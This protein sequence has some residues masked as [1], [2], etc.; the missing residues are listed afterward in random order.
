MQ[1]AQLLA[2]VGS[3][4]R[5]IRHQGHPVFGLGGHLQ[6]AAGHL[7]CRHIRPHPQ[8]GHRIRHQAHAP[9]LQ[10]APD[11]ADDGRVC[12]DA[13]RDKADRHARVGQERARQPRLAMHERRHR[14]EQ[15][16]AVAN[17]RVEALDGL[18]VGCHGVARAHHDPAPDQAADHVE[19]ARQLRR[20]GDD[21][22]AG[23]RRPVAHRLEA[24]RPQIVRVVGA[25]LLDVEEG[26]F[27]VQAQRQRAAEV[28]GRVHDDLARGRD[29]LQRRG[30]DGRQERGHPVARILCRDRPNRGWVRGEIV[31]EPAVELQVDEPRREDQAVRVEPRRARGTGHIG[32]GADRDDP[33][34]VDEHRAVGD[35]DGGRVGGGM[36]DVEHGHWISGRLAAAMDCPTRR[37][38]SSGSCRLMRPASSGNSAARTARAPS[39]MICPPE[40]DVTRPRIRTWL[41]S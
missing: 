33:P 20:Q 10:R 14:V 23:L 35:G 26:A 41:R 31:A 7:R 18:V 13:V 11:D 37:L 9:A 4:R 3:V 5:V 6:A 27:D 8:R 36:M 2:Q 25:L 32:R 38:F 1:Q 40:P 21:P 12:V 28:R 34:A 16:C 30:D 39:R 15:V 24:R 19:R 29:R 17:A 22:H